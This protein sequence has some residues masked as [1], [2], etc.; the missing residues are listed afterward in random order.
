VEDN[1]NYSI[2]HDLLSILW[3]F[4]NH[5]AMPAGPGPAGVDD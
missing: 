2:S 4:G 3:Q 1:K 5:K